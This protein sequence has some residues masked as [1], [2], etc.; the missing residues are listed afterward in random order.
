[1]YERGLILIFRSA[2]LLDL[3]LIETLWDR[4][5]DIIEERHPKVY[6]SYYWFLGSYY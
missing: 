4:I 6:W 5:K 2:L 3:N 1:M